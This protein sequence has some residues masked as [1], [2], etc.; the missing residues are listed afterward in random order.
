MENG[1]SEVM[2]PS[3]FLEV[4]NV[5]FEKKTKKNVKIYKQQVKKKNKNKI[6]NSYT[7]NMF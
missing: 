3:A 5:C 4:S 7:N 2:E 1:K 6:K